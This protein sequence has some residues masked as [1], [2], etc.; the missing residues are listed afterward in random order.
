MKH[1]R[2]RG[3]AGD[4]LVEIV[5]AIVLI[6]IVAAGFFT[7]VMTSATA[8]KAHREVTTADEV[9]R[10]YA[11]AAVQ[12]ARDTPADAG[13]SGTAIPIDYVPP[14]GYQ[15]SAT[16]LTCPDAGSAQLVHITATTPVGV[17]KNLYI[18]VRMR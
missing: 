6:G 12:S 1:T 10:N 14:A 7:A 18:D 16:G 2:C 9:L 11:E 5:F 3:E 4:S 13:A 8:S 15:V 17:A